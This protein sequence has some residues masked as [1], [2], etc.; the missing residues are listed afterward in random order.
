MLSAEWRR[1]L[2]NQLNSSDFKMLFNFVKKEYLDPSQKC[3]PPAHQIFNAYQCAN[4]DNIKVVILG[5]D[6]YINER[7][8]MGMCFSI[9]QGVKVPPSLKNIY[10]ALQN[11]DKI[12]F[13][14]PNPMH[15]D[16]T[17]WAK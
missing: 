15:G 5:Q 2:Q 6:P 17:Q 7:E 1:P 8:A 13:K 10:L 12:D 11:D 4:F 16:L 9:N 14:M 3:Y